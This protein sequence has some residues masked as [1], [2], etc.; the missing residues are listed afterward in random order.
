VA[1]RWLPSGQQG[2][3]CYWSVN[4]SFFFLPLWSRE[5][6]ATASFGFFLPI[7]TAI[8]NLYLLETLDSTKKADLL[9]KQLSSDSTPS[10][11]SPL[12]V[13]IQINTSLESNKNGIPPLP[14]PSSYPAE[15]AEKEENPL[16]LAQHI[17][18]SCPSLRLLGL[19]TIG[20]FDNSHKQGEEGNPDFKRL[21]QT[22]EELVKG[23][24]ERGVEASK[25]GRVEEEGRLELSMGM[26]ADFEEALK[27]G[28]DSVRVGT[29]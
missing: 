3:A 9:E 26:S 28:S 22:R 16:D 18:T 21:V 20:S 12:N 5:A 24:K 14:L 29:R 17:I 2:E 10:R 8:P 25:F 4:P 11:S 1:L 15:D 7:S 6:H 23:L 13:Y 19:M 27:S